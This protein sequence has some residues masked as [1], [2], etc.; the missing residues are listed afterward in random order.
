M[1]KINNLENPK[2][3]GKDSVEIMNLALKTLE[4]I[5][6]EVIESAIKEFETT[7]RF[8]MSRDNGRLFGINKLSG[9]LGTI[10]L[11]CKSGDPFESFTLYLNGSVIFKGAL[12]SILHVNIIMRTVLGA[13]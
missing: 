4:E 7:G 1:R 9:G 3:K 8:T 13:I 10:T 2:N 12:I 11:S 6:T 5:H